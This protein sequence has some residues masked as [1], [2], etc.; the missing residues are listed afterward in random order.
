MGELFIKGQKTPSITNPSRE[1]QIILENWHFF[2]PRVLFFICLVFCWFRGVFLCFSARGG[3][4][5]HGERNMLESYV[6]GGVSRMCSAMFAFAVA[7]PCFC[8]P[9]SPNVK[10]PRRVLFH[11]HFSHALGR[12][13]PFG[14]NAATWAGCSISAGRRCGDNGS[15]VAVW[16][17]RF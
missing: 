9:W 8:P 13:L 15:F 11:A 5:P 17:R 7:F 2:E 16:A 14:I 12:D 3:G 6:W 4:R 10:V 1:A